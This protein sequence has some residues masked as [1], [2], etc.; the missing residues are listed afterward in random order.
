M[1]NETEI[2]YDQIE[3]III[4]QGIYQNVKG[5]DDN[6]TVGIIICKQ[7]NQCVIG[8]CSDDRIIV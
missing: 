4:N 5:L 1:K 6:K 2:I 7:I 3:N 8:Y